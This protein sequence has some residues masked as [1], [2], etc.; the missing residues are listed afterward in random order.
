M[1]NCKNVLLNEPFA[2]KYNKII[3]RTSF[4]YTCKGDMMDNKIS[5][6]INFKPCSLKVSK[7]A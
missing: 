3:E 1:S 4:I 2:T 6:N 5:S 7:F